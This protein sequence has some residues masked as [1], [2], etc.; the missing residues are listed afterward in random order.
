VVDWPKKHRETLDQ[1]M[2][3]GAA[4]VRYDCHGLEL[5]SECRA[6]GAY[7]FLG[8]VGNEE[9]IR[10][11]GS[12]ELRLNLPASSGRWAASEPESLSLTLLTVGARR[13]M[14]HDVTRE[15]LEGTCDGATHVVR[16]ALLGAFRVT[17]GASDVLSS[18]SDTEFATCRKVSP[19][20]RAA[21]AECGRVLKL[22]LSRLPEASTTNRSALDE[23]AHPPICP[24]G[25]VHG[26]GKC[27]RVNA[28]KTHE[29]S[30]KDPAE[31]E[32]QCRA[33]NAGS[34][35][36]LGL[37]YWHGKKV[38]SDPTQ[39]AHYMQQGCAKGEQSACAYLGTLLAQSPGSAPDANRTRQLLETA[40]D[41]GEAF[42]CVSLG[43][44]CAQ[45]GD[46]ERAME[47]SERGCEGGNSTG[48]EN[49]GLGYLKGI[50]R[51]ENHAQA[52][53]FLLRACDGGSGEACHYLARLTA[54]EPALKAEVER[55]HKG[56]PLL[57]ERAC[58]AGNAP[59]CEALRAAAESQQALCVEGNATACSLIGHMF[60]H[61]Y[62]V[63]QD[64]NRAVALF[65]RACNGGVA[66]SCV[67]L[68]VFYL[69]LNDKRVRRDP[70][71]ASLVLG[72]ACDQGV[73][74]AC[75]R[76]AVLYDEGDGVVVDRARAWRLLT[77]ACNR[78][79]TTVCAALKAR[80]S[81][82]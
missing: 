58:V 75:A 29:C 82:Q 13:A 79:M 59:S 12:E 42:A 56:F 44:V 38:R 60:L 80:T 69:N 7:G 18:S 20:D 19:A 77:E 14:V 9:T 4:V 35:R 36:R 6:P 64:P 40:C 81:S 66:L 55:D 37:M 67:G 11:A 51:T 25:F 34:C 1:L 5:L 41:R 46:N 74:E 32:T 31:C 43:A 73:A 63:P 71:R 39:A 2:S 72:Q 52:A 22:E 48:C 33:G 24:F 78:G 26:E 54:E 57:H 47:L 76:L 16:G 23:S 17:E 50:G 53:R 30:L 15:H 27:A 68:G 61:G 65:E 8:Y 70:R 21:S 3:R 28:V 62:G 45:S 10:L 49:L